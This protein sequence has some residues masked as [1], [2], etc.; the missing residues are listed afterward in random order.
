MTGCHSERSHVHRMRRFKAGCV[1]AYMQHKTRHYRVMR[2]SS[3]ELKQAIDEPAQAL[4]VI[5]LTATRVRRNLS[6]AE[7]DAVDLET[8]DRAVRVIKRF[9]LPRS[10]EHDWS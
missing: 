7:Q 6:E 8:A 1:R 2:M 9:Q 10:D 4:Q 5:T 3:D